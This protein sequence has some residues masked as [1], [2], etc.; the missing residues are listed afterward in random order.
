MMKNVAKKSERV[1]GQAAQAS[2][3]DERIN[4]LFAEKKALVAAI[5][6]RNATS[7]SRC[8]ENA[9]VVDWL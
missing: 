9:P 6:K 1:E 4:K 7:A 3:T 5:R 2:S 8:Q